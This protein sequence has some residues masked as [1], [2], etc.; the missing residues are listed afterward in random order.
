MIFERRCSLSMP[1]CLDNSWRIFERANRRTNER[2]GKK[3][4]SFNVNM[5]HYLPFFPSSLS[6]VPFR[7]LL[8]SISPSLARSFRRS[9]SSIVILPI[10]FFIIFLCRLKSFKEN[11]I[12]STEKN[13]RKRERVERTHTHLH[14]SG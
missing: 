14:V 7:P 5:L 11:G 9:L 1:P 2:K 3:F 4:I 12:Y 10:S 8:H 13:E 6:I